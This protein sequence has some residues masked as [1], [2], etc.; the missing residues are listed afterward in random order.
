MASTALQV[1]ADGSVTNITVIAVRGY[2]PPR[3]TTPALVHYLAEVFNVLHA[4]PGKVVDPLVSDDG[5][6][7]A[8][9][10][11]DNDFYVFRE[12]TVIGADAVWDT[13][14]VQ[15]L[16]FSAAQLTD[17]EDALRDTSHTAWDSPTFALSATAS[18]YVTLNEPKCTFYYTK[19]IGATVAAVVAAVG[20][21]G[22]RSVARGGSLIFTIIALTLT[23]TG[24]AIA[25]VILYAASMTTVI[26]ALKGGRYTRIVR[27]S[28]KYN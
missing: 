13:R 20:E 11:G 27:T 18:H 28:S 7:A 23:L 15:A 12:A 10:C 3:N 6:A 14:I 21:L 9:R 2:P 22:R 19:G 17:F 16:H 25:A 26:F 5:S 1:A 4:G 24:I 8:L